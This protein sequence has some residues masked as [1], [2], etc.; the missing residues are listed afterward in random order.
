MTNCTQLY[1]INYNFFVEDKKLILEIEN[2]KNKKELIDVKA[3][4]ISN[5]K[6]VFETDIISKVE[7]I[8][9]TETFYL[10][11]LNDRT[12][13]TDINNKN[14]AKG[15]A[16]TVYISNYEE[17]EQKALDTIQTNRYNHNVTFDL[18]NRIIK[19]GTPVA[20]KTKDSTI[21]DTYIS[22]IKITTN[23][24]IEYTCGNIRIKFIDKLK[25]ER[26]KK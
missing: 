15:K 16:E 21:L 13:T 2:K 14:R 24:F 5:Y 1:N 19:L 6:E 11:L 8:T 12:T 22:A 23:Q 3:H 26:S 4:A 25:K 10:Y 18:L 20:I 17:A 7:V 9:D